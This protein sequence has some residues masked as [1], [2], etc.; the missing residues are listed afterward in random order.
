MC[1]EQR[2]CDVCSVGCGS[3]VKQVVEFANFFVLT[4]TVPLY[5]HGLFRLLRAITVNIK[6]QFG[7]NSSHH[8][9]KIALRFIT[10]ISFSVIN[11]ANYVFKFQK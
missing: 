11:I 4:H 10:Q 7:I 2:V 3:V 8:L 5:L 6:I 9:T 1:A